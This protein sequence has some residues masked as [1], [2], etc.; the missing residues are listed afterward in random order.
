M[1]EVIGKRLAGEV[2]SSQVT[3]DF[4]YQAEEFGLCPENGVGG[5]E[6]F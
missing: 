3:E 5:V 2:V 1:K 4:L 6:E